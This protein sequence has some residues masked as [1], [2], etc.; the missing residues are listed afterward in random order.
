MKIF[1]IFHIFES[2]VTC[3]KCY[4]CFS[5]DLSVLTC[6]CLEVMLVK[7]RLDV[8][9]IGDWSDDS[10]LL[11]KVI[12]KLADLSQFAKEIPLHLKWNDLIL[13]EFYQQ[14][15]KEVLESFQFI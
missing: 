1:L 12:I 3:H 6:F 4:Y 2:T 9:L 15:E 14:G 5:K 11:C 10:T 8:K 13:D 7:S